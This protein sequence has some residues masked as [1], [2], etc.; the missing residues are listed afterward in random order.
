[1]QHLH[2]L[3]Q[4]STSVALLLDQNLLLFQSFSQC[5]EYLF[6]KENRISSY[7]IRFVE[8]I[9]LQ[10]LYSQVVN[11]GVVVTRRL[12]GHLMFLVLLVWVLVDALVGS[13]L[14]N[15]FGDVFSYASYTS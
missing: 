8:T 13:A 12:V 14:L 6:P 10:T 7:Q 2:L 1:M 4:R 3:D 9:V 11:I 15:V 5:Q